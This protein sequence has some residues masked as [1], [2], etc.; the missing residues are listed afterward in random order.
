MCY[1]RLMRT[2]SKTFLPGLKSILEPYK[3]IDVAVSLG[4]HQSTLSQ[5]AGCKRGASLEMA[6][7]IARVLNTT[8]EA[9]AVSDTESKRPQKIL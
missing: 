6:L 4:I 1:D 3:V 8:V 7:K 2:N 5:L 9:L